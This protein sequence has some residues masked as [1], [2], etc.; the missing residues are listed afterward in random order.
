MWCFKCEL[1]VAYYMHHIVD[2]F[3]GLITT[4]F[5][6][7]NVIISILSPKKVLSFT[8][9]ALHKWLIGIMSASC[10]SKHM[11]LTK[12]SWKSIDFDKK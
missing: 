2:F 4:L 6:Y 10:N 9:F 11:L 3:C 1:E 7:Y 5:C 12:P 8:V